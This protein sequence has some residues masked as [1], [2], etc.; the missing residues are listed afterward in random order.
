MACQPDRPTSDFWNLALTQSGCLTRMKHGGRV[1]RIDG[2][3]EKELK[4]FCRHFYSRFQLHCVSI[5][6]GTRRLVYK[7]CFIKSSNAII[8]KYRPT[9][10]QNETP[11]VCFNDQF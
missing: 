9:I 6:R 4:L 11:G 3:S 7:P 2:G 10:F 1:L 8:V 5:N